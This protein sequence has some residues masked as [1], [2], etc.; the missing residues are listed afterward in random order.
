MCYCFVTL[1][2][3]DCTRSFYVVE[4]QMPFVQPI[5]SHELNRAKPVLFEEARSVVVSWN[6]DRACHGDLRT[7]KPFLSGVDCSSAPDPVLSR[8]SRSSVRGY[9]RPYVHVTCVVPKSDHRPVAGRPTP[10]PPP[11][12]ASRLVRS[13][14]CPVQSAA[15]RPWVLPMR[16]NWNHPR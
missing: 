13:E 14:R 1:P 9:F 4:E 11:G 12:E 16:A 15:P 6:L 7:H 10:S 5:G 8:H 2:G 3:E